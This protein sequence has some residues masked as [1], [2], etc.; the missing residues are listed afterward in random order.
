M[1][2]DIIYIYI[3]IQNVYVNE[4]TTCAILNVSRPYMYVYICMHVSFQSWS[5]P[6]SQQYDE[7]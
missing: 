4:I 2:V 1:Y 6:E 3:C 5:K 7:S